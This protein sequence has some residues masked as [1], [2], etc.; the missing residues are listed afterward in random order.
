MGHRE[1]PV[2]VKCDASGACKQKQQPGN[3]SSVSE[4]D[5]EGKLVF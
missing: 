5:I 2:I 3:V 4:K 1:I